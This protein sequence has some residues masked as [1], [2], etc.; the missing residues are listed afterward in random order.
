MY[1]LRTI[2]LEMFSKMAMRWIYVS[3]LRVFIS[4]AISSKSTAIKAHRHNLLLVYFGEAS[5]WAFAPLLFL[6]SI[7]WI[8]G[9]FQAVHPGI[10]HTIQSHMKYIL[11]TYIVEYNTN[12]WTLLFAVYVWSYC[13]Q[14]GSRTESRN[15]RTSSKCISM[16][17]KLRLSQH[18]RFGFPVKFIMIEMLSIQP[19][20]FS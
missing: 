20:L 19:G 13:A 2:Q 1:L 12:K 6:H 7:Q 18:N 9:I 10:S 3:I 5:N 4:H 11:L 8:I 16:S 15:Y 14:Y 17:G